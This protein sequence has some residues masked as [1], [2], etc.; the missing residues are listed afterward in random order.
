MRGALDQDYYLDG[1]TT[2]PSTEF[3]ED[4]MRKAKALGLNLLRVHIKVPDPRYY[5]VADRLGILVWT[6]IP[7]AEIFSD[8]SA[9]RMRETMEGILSRDGNHPSIVA[10]TLVNEDWGT[11]LRESV[12]Q[13]QWLVEFFDWLKR[14]DPTR[15]VVDNSPCAPN[16]H[17]KTDINDFHYYRTVPE[18][19]SEWD[20]LTA[21]FAA[22]ADWTFSP[23]GDAVRTGDEPL[24]VSEFGVWGLPQIAPL[25]GPDGADPWW[26]ASGDL[27][28]DGAANP[29]GVEER[30]QTLRLEEVFGSFDRFVEATQWYQ[31]A[32][33][34]YEIERLRTYPSIAGYVVTEL[35]DVHWEANGLMD[36]ARNPRVFGER[37]A[38]IN[39]DIVI[40][41]GLE[42]WAYWAGE[43]VS[44]A[45]QIASG[46]K[47]VPAG[48][49]LEWRIGRT[50][51]RIEV[52]ALGPL[53][54]E[55]VA[56]LTVSMPQLD[57]AAMV[58]VEFDLYGPDGGTLAINRATIA[59]HPERARQGLVRVASD[60]AALR[61]RFA[62]LGYEPSHEDQADVFA[63]RRLDATRIEAIEAGQNVLLLAEAA[64]E[65]RSLRTDAPP[66]EQPHVPIVDALPGLPAQPYFTFP[67]YGLT[68]R[69]NTIWRGD[70]V[71][72]FS[73]LKRTGAFAGLPGGPLF[74]LSF[75]RVVPRAVITG[76]R[77]W[78]FDGRIHGAVAVGW[79]HKPAAAVMEKTHGRGKL[80]A[81]TF[82][83][84]EDAPGIDPTATALMDGLV[85]LASSLPLPR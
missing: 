46:G 27:W 42:R 49:T 77:P 65:H 39:T 26:F 76:F 58:D 3:L 62:A 16:Y 72:N 13:R 79:L 18:R 54:V 37:F 60:D 84:C 33:L 29:Q 10:W 80:V 40:L 48:S 38:E 82:R 51:G 75:D 31:F 4:Q 52:P 7:N 68:S 66:R 50:S 21:E 83:L 11:R 67:G 8:H 64:N 12:N 20:Q 28:S 45:A 73:W 55:P 17:V 59:L 30:F 35:T 34:K 63:T 14:A 74:D 78:E 43:T 32:N 56:G 24:V 41:P 1:I 69:D 15:L 25:R 5:E 9:R 71:T 61:E 2:P 47:A 85:R 23:H 6:E 19:R 57:V 70:W 81:A 22:G 44:I 36:M 53:Q